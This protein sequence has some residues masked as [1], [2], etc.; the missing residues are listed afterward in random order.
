MANKNKVKKGKR[1]MTQEE[2]LILATKL[3]YR[4]VDKIDKMIESVVL[5]GG[6]PCDSLLEEKQ[7]YKEAYSALVRQSIPVGVHTAAL[8][9][10]REQ[11]KF[12]S[13]ANLPNICQS[14]YNS[15]IIDFKAGAEWM[16]R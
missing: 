12:D 3:V 5:K 6:I 11:C 10:V 13:K 8:E 9:Y 16:A 14:C 4:Q 15:M 7:K 1:I 2:A